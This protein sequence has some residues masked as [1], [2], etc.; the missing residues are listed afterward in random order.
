VAGSFAEF[1]LKLFQASEFFFNTLAVAPLPVCVVFQ[2]MGI[3]FGRSAS[4]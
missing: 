1:V 4:A 2:F 3:A